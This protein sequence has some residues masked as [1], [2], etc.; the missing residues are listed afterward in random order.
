MRQTVSCDMLDHM[1]MTDKTL[2]VVENDV[3]T[4]FCSTD[5]GRSKQVGQKF[6]HSSIEP[7]WHDIH[8]DREMHEVDRRGSPCRMIFVALMSQSAW[9][10]SAADNFEYFLSL[11]T[12]STSTVGQIRGPC[13]TNSRIIM[14][15]GRL[16]IDLDTTTLRDLI[17]SE[18]KLFHEDP[19]PGGME[20]RQEA[21]E[22]M[23]YRQSYH[24]AVIKN[25]NKV[26]KKTIGTV[27][28][29]YEP[30]S[31][32]ENLDRKNE[33]KARGTLLMVLPNKYQLKFHSYQD[34]KLIMKVIE[35]RY[36]GN[37]E[38][39]EVQR[40]LLKQ[41]Y[42]NFT[43]SISK[44]LDQ[45]FDRL[46]KLISR[47]EFQGLQSVE[48][49][50][51]HY[52]KNK[53]VFEEKYN[54]LN[55][56]VR[57]RDNAL[58]EY[59]KK[60][61]KTEKK[62]DE[63]KLTLKKYQNSFKSLNTLLESQVSDKVK[64]RLGYKAA[65]HAVE[66]FVNS[67][68]MIENQENVKSI[69]DKGYHAVPPPYTGNYIPPRPDLMFI[70]KQVKSEYVDVVSNISS[71]AVKTVESKVESIDVKNKG[72]YN[73][74]ETN[75]IK[76]NSFSPPI[77]EDSISDDESEVEFEPKVKDKT[78]RPSIEK[79]K[80]VKPASEK[81]ERVET[82]KQHKH[83]PRGNQRNWNN[84]MSQRLGRNKCYLTDYEDYDGG[85]VSFGDGKGK[86][87]GKCKIKT[88]TLDFDDLYFWIKREFSVAKTPQHNSVVKRKTITLIEAAK[89]YALVI[90]PH[91]K[92]PYELI[93]RRP[94]LIDFMKPFGC[95]FTILNTRD[96]LGKFNEGFFI[97]SPVNTVGPSYVNVASPSPINDAGT[98]AST[99]AFKEHLFER[100]SPFKN[101]FSFPHV[102]IMTLI[103][104][105]RI[106]GNA[107]DDEAVEEEVDM[108]NVVLSYT[109]PD[110][111]LTKFLE[112]HPKDQVFRNK[113]DER[114]IVIKNKDRLVAQGHTQEEGIDYDEVFAPVA[115]I[116]AIRLFLGYATFQQKS[117][118]IFINQDKY[119]VDILKK[120]DFT[121]IKTASTLMEP[122]KALVKDAE[123]EDID[124]HL[125]RSMIGSLMYLTTSRADITF[126]VCACATFQVTLKTLQIHDV[127]RIFRYLKGQPKLGLWYPRDSP[128]DLEAYSNS[129]Y[130]RASLEMKSTTGG[131]QFLGKRLISLQCKKQTIVAN[132]TTE[133]EYV[134][135]TS[136]YR[137][138]DIMEMDATTASSLEAEHDSDKQVEGMAKHKEIYVISSHTK[139]VFANIRRQG[140]GFSGNVTPLFDTMMVNAQ[141]EV[142][143]GSGLLTDSHHTPTD[144]QPEIHVEES[145]PTPSNDP[146][147]SGK[148]SI[149]LNEL[150]IF[151]TNLQQ[152]VLDLKEAKTTQAK[153]IANFKKR[154]KKLEKKR[155][156]RPTVL[157]RLKKRK[158]LK[159]VSTADPVIVDVE[160][161]TAASVEDSAAPTTTTTADVDDELTLTKTLISIKVSKPKIISTAATTVTSD[162]TTPRAKVLSSM[163]KQLAE[164]IQAQER[165]QLS[166]KERSK[167]LAELI[168]SRRKYFSA[169]RAEEIR[170]KPPTKA[171]Q[172]SLMCIY[173]KNMKGFKQK[174]FKGKS[175]DDIKKI[176]DKVYKK[177]NTFMDMNTENVEESLKKT[178]AE[179]TEGSSKRAG[180]ELEQESVK[181][182]KLMSREDL[183]VLRIIVK[184]MFKK[185]NPVDDMENLLFQTLKTMFEHHVKD[186]IWKY[187]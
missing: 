14:P 88:G 68:K 154:F 9:I 21:I 165:E 49:R 178:Q 94:P 34:T 179:V 93:R 153:E 62:R 6:V 50:L 11:V 78:V 27:E 109:I 29:I 148:D 133:T 99:N 157:K 145:I 28:Q 86:I 105:T 75:P 10:A 12:P 20:I 42:E 71:S 130:A 151:C 101:A 137:Q 122:N 115:R 187:Q 142:G 113:K 149:Q 126:S 161:V 91:N 61:E 26:L 184:E 17:D 128:L 104:D 183:E 102:T 32:E 162:I 56:K 168:E 170:N 37:K 43:T 131:C 138:E 111:P 156:T 103:N 51:V 124:V 80:F 55:L 24:W 82:P 25:G 139:K 114:G 4:V 77:I 81:V 108:N 19:Q 7:H 186:I 134:A 54:I 167:L 40:I 136:C 16:S 172:K 3:D 69:L 141:E 66:N 163:N 59:T 45:T 180:E 74:V 117:D 90:K 8:V 132:S 89:N 5:V 41:Q 92:T 98:P 23:E 65:S 110:L 70:D 30:T 129:D 159:K 60:L 158:L 140:Q 18:G 118:G 127:K 107:Y 2:H 97:G 171:Q 73:A 83:Y 36:G 125:Y 44:T 106:F 173:M 72:V 84:L 57:L 35:K 166:I 155:K 95:P 182:Q 119:V 135:A 175:F 174:D 121:T 123:A 39:K 63:L 76:K 79:I 176:F 48:E 116:K 112:D 87:S 31:V 160:V 67:S 38:S 185:T 147:P 146:L 13:L 96:Y 53:A 85:F 144:T 52:K 169:K 33:I 181:K 58:V 1:V 100:F 22:R 46:Q 152:Q 143:K 120:F 47:L 15:F 177:V 150:M 164:Q 64:T